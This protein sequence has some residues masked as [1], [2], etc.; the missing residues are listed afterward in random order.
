MEWKVIRQDTSNDSLMHYGTRGMRWGERQYQYE[1]GSY[2]SAGKE[3]YSQKSGALRSR[4]RT[5]STTQGSDISKKSD[6][7]IIPIPTGLISAVAT[8]AETVKDQVYSEKEY[9]EVKKKLDE[10]DWIDAFDATQ[11]QYMHVK[12]DEF[13]KHIRELVENGV[14]VEMPYINAADTDAET[15]KAAREMNAQIRYWNE[16]VQKA[17]KE[18]DPVETYGG[19]DSEDLITEDD[20]KKLRESIAKRKEEQR[21]KREE[22]RKKNEELTQSEIVWTV[23]RIDK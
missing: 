5:T 10:K 16:E 23:E 13:G 2:T 3:R 6:K 15:A 20:Q 17:L 9:V 11:G 7:A 21:K 14:V 12:R 18:E 22:A 19:S 1:D 4:K 8:L